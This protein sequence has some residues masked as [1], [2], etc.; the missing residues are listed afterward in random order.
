MTKSVPQALRDL[1]ELYE[2]RNKLYKNNY[3]NFGKMI[4]GMIPDG[5][6]LKTEEDFNRFALFMQLVHKCS[7]YAHNLTNG[8]HDDSLDDL[9]VYS[10]M[11]REFDGLMKDEKLKATFDAPKQET[12][13]TPLQYAED[14]KNENQRLRNSFENVAMR[15]RRELHNDEEIALAIENVLEGK[16]PFED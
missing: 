16:L 6:E 10:Q 12:D 11:L 9:S 1:G 4:K 14:L 15:V 13:T 2:E 3:L 8:G 7:R 5:V